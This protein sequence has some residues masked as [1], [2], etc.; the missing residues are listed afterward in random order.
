MKRLKRFDPGQVV[1]TPGALAAFEASG[2]SLLDYLERHLSG[3]LGDVN[4][5]DARENELSLK[6]GW[7]LLSAIFCIFLTYSR[8]IPQRASPNA[9]SSDD[10]P[11]E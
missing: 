7:R 2:D 10:V 9:C 1:A 11:I 3:D 6:Y 8:N 5:E 4:P